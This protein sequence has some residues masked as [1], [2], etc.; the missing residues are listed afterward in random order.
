MDHCTQKIEKYQANTHIIMFAQIKVSVHD[1]NCVFYLFYVME[2][3]ICC[4]VVK[5]YEIYNTKFRL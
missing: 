1:F 2:T 4:S 3:Y 5:R